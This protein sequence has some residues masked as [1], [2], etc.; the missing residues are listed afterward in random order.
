MNIRMLDENH[1]SISL[2]ETTSDQ[3]VQSI[4]KLFKGIAKKEKAVS[5]YD[6]PSDILRSSEY[7][8]HPVFH[9]YRT[10]TEMLRYI[11]KL[12][13]K[14]IALDRAM[15]PLG[16]CTM[17]LNAA[18][19]MIP[20]G[21]E[22]FSNIHPYAPEDQV[23]GYKNLIEDLETKLSEITGYAAVSLQP[24]AGS[25]GEYAGLLAI[26]A[27]HRSNGDQQRKICLIPESAHGTNPASA[28]MAG[29]RVVPISCD[30]KG[31]IDLEDLKEKAAQ[32][33]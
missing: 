10:E 5:S 19:E 22:E 16:S 2:D 4:A 8:T 28:Q 9:L 13:D 26:D 18:S 30:K 24:N 14:D 17:K 29:M 32:S 31:N 15:I 33:F 3:E 25:Q 6:L 1:I 27:F 7:L 23:A 12:C 20:V 21:W 11:R